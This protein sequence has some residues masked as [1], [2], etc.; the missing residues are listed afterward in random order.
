MVGR[1]EALD[2]QLLPNLVPF[3][4]R[5]LNL[6]FLIDDFDHRKERVF[7]WLVR[8]LPMSFPNPLSLRSR[9]PTPESTTKD[10]RVA[11]AFEL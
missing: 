3:Q 6:L 8:A 1:G 11:C 2:L 4:V 9:V 10:G 7:Y 5:D